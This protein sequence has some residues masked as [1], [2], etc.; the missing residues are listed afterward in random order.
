MLA[1][2]GRSACYRG[3]FS[4]MMFLA[5]HYLCHDLRYSV[6]IFVALTFCPP[7]YAHTHLQKKT[8]KNHLRVQRAQVG[9]VTLIQRSLT[10]LVRDVKIFTPVPWNLSLRDLEDGLPCAMIRFS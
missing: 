7:R 9:Q 5:T 8:T 4:L 10:P 1:T 2:I 6:F 3:T